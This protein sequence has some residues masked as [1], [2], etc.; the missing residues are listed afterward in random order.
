MQEVISL[1]TMLRRITGDSELVTDDL[2]PVVRRAGRR[3]AKQL[4]S[5]AEATFRDT[6][7]ARNSAENMAL[8]CGTRYGEAVQASEIADPDMVTLVCESQETLAGFA[9]LRWGGAP[10]CVVAAAPGEIQR[11]YVARKFHGMGVARKLML[12][13]LDE[14]RARRSD[15]VWLGVWEHNPRAIAFYRKFGFAEV[16]E[17][18]FPLG[19][20]PQR[21]I[22]MTWSVDGGS[23]VS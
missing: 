12:A 15:V 22:V 18:I 6:F 1:G 17:H 21:D 4:A 23:P 16:G 11:L 14:M 5:L 9:Q 2:S 3:D 20:D 19:R 13:C 10:R 7:E 8:H